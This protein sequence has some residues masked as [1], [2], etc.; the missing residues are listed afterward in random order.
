MES[1]LQILQESEQKAAGFIGRAI[2]IRPNMPTP[3]QAQFSRLVATKLIKMPKNPDQVVSLMEQY[4]ALANS[5]DNLTDNLALIKVSM[6]TRIESV[7]G[8][9]YASTLRATL[10]ALVKI[11]CMDKPQDWFEQCLASLVA[12]GLVEVSEDNKRVWRVSK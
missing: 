12:D 6:M 1:K 4:G 5:T 7:E 2:I 8:I 11:D 10:A 9:L 3:Q